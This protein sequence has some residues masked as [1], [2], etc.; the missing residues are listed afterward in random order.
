MASEHIEHKL[1]LL[2]DKPGCYQ[3][4]NLNSQIIYVGKAKNLKNRVRSYFKSSHEGK[5]AK[6]VSEIADFDYI[7]TS[8]DKEAFLLEIT[9]IQKFQPYYNIKLKKGT[10]YPYI[11]ITNEKDPRME[12]VSSVR[13]DGGF[14]FGPYPNVYA[15]EET[16][17][18]LEKVY[19][20]RRCNGFQ[21]R[22]CL[23]YHM[24]Q[25]L[26][27]CFQ[28]VP[29]EEYDQQ[30]AKIKSFLRGNVA[31]IKQSLQTK[32][33][34]AS[35]AMEFERAA[36]IRDQIHYIE[37]TVEK[38]KIISNDS[39]P[40]D[41][42][43]FYLDKGWLSIQIFFIRQ[44]RLIK[45]EKRL[46]PIATD[47]SDELSSFI[48]QFY[49]NKNK[50]LPNE[51][52]VPSGLDNKIMAEILG[53]P[54][55]TPQRGEKKNLLELA[56]ENAQITLE[57]KFRLME[58]DES[59]TTGA[60]KEI[61]DALGIP[62]GHRIEAFDHSHI[63][64]SELVSAMVVFT[65]GKP[66]KKMYRKFKLN[67][68][69]HADEAASTREVI[70][71]RYVRLLKEKQSLPDLI[72]MDGGDIQLNAAKDV[73]VNELSL[74]IPVA[75]MVKNDEHK[76]SDLIFGSQDQ[77]V[78]LDPKSQGFYLVQ[79]IQ[80]E[81]HRFAITFHRQLH[82]KNSLASQLD[83]I[84]GVGPKTRNKLLKSFG[85]LNKIRDANLKE[86][87]ELGIPEKVAK[88]IKVSLSVHGK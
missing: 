46:F 71:R 87:E 24:G 13:R 76:T 85:S 73:L 82:A 75:G 67:T 55:R 58:L 42:F 47:V 63:Q 81:V 72:L 79:R 60:M 69:D 29:K 83:L 1:A 37:V 53:I 45:R 84:Q 33:Q 19:P 61:T 65:D 68:V 15:A 16:L 44:S 30:I 41:L 50:V 35:E 8:S 54:V 6:L 48:L 27:A 12:I 74:H 64:G 51:I 77:R 86:I 10:G 52:L 25:C 7:V 40:R 39:T 78:Q 18:F 26:G 3:M 23:Y 21:G 62:E 34:K 36:D 59:K 56:K 31:K 49:N 4:K 9:L 32:M 57:E 38:Q 88:T 17:H 80:D 5:T 70:R 43:N 28:E 22:P 66:D 2:P 14:Y 20:L 11:K